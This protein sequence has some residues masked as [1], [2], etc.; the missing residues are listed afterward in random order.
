M[1]VQNSN[2]TARKFLHGKEVSSL[3]H[4]QYEFHMSITFPGSKGAINIVEPP[5][6]TLNTKVLCIMLAKLFSC[7]LLQSISILRLY[8]KVIGSK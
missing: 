4:V 3:M 6:P 7:E 5:D 8:E 2:I 1:D